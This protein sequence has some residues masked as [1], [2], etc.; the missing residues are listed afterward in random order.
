MSL[1]SS[2]KLGRSR[3]RVSPLWLGAM[4]FGENVGPAFGSSVEDFEAILAHDLE[5][6]KE[7]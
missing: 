6:G 4:T 1:N 5:R 7:T 3:P 2:L